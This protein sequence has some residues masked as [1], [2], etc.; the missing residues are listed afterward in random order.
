M[1]KAFLEVTNDSTK[2]RHLDP[3]GAV[4]ILDCRSLGSYKIQQGVL[5]QSLSK[6]YFLNPYETK[7]KLAI[8]LEVSRRNY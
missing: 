2:V 6:Y 3:K 8:I 5:Q 4:V 1:K 7:L